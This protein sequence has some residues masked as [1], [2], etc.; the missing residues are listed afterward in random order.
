MASALVDLPS[1]CSCMGP[2]TAGIPGLDER[3][4]AFM[5]RLRNLAH[6]ALTWPHLNGSTAADVGHGAGA[7]CCAFAGA[8]PEFLELSWKVVR[9]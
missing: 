8:A 6:E 4:A 1:S 7:G 5:E 9:C 2:P 3:D